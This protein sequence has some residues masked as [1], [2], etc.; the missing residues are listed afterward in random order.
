MATLPTVTPAALDPVDVDTA[1]R[2]A[3][4]GRATFYGLVFDGAGRPCE[5]A[6]LWYNGEARA[7]TDSDGRYRIEVV[8][9]HVAFAGLRPVF[10]PLA[11]VKVGTGVAVQEAPPRGRRVDLTLQQTGT[12][13]GAVVNAR[14]GENIDGATVNLVTL[15]QFRGCSARRAYHVDVQTEVD[16]SFHL[17]AAS[18][19]VHS[20]AASKP[21]M[22]MNQG[23]IFASIA[24]PVTLKLWPGGRLR[25]QF[26]PWPPENSSQPVV[27]IY[28]AMGMDF[29]VLPTDQ[30]AFELLA[31]ARRH[32]LRSMA[33]ESHPG[34]LW[35]QQLPSH[36][37]DLGTLTLPEPGFFFGRV[38]LSAEMLSL[39]PEIMV[40]TMAG[41]H[42]FTTHFELG[43]GGYF[44][45]GPL[46]PGRTSFGLS[47][48]SQLITPLG[49]LML[50]PGCQEDVGTLPID[51]PVV[52]GRVRDSSGK[53]IAR[54]A[55]VELL[56]PS[57]S[58]LAGCKV[59]DEARYALLLPVDAE[60]DADG[61]QLQVRART[62]GLCEALEWVKLGEEPVYRELT[63]AEGTELSGFA[64]DA[65]DRP[66]TDWLVVARD[67]QGQTSQGD[68]V[69]ADGSF[70]ICGLKRALYDL[71]LESPAGE[72]HVR[73][74]HRAGEDPVRLEVAL[75]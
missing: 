60:V 42:K 19:G 64:F 68:W 66:L 63:L 28:S 71:V 25:G 35:R 73:P 4:R 16:G 10:A 67:P 2:E 6:T 53:G 1:R 33:L 30:G 8:H 72:Q 5:D 61:Q 15:M 39:Q 3:A 38:T 9:E 62:P 23:R 22:G 17:P 44:R 47:L 45:A 55:Q 21:G 65:A 48:G 32:Q 24:E 59:D 13:E 36:G 57:G 34:L 43:H 12:I 75:P 54:R 74:D 27:R 52:L 18:Q 41:D 58:F 51:Q 56:S 70:K 20:V 49:V 26:Q 69:A 37:D 40:L 31:T 14:S 29:E 7:R 50:T 11:A 46:P